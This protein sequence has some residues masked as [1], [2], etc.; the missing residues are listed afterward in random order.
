[1]G[2]ITLL[3]I[4]VLLGLPSFSQVKNDSLTINT[5]DTAYQN[6]RDSIGISTKVG[7][8]ARYP[9]GDMV[10]RN[11]LVQNLNI[12]AAVKDLPKNN[13]RYRETVWVQ[14]IVCIDGTVCDIKVLNDVLPSAKEE[15]ERVIK[16]SGNWEPA[17]LDGRKIKAYRKQPITF[18][19]DPE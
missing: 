5:P 4:L 3:F 6:T 15:A 9:G 11:F 19:F 7:I 14:F 16:K 1:M 18:V 2:K 10:W 12:N 17:S 8:E 13:N